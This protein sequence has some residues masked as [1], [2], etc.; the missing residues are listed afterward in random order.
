MQNYNK[1]VTRRFLIRAAGRLHRQSVGIDV[2]HK[3][4]PLKARIHE[5]QSI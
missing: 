3:R 4:Q 2:F 5:T 1:V